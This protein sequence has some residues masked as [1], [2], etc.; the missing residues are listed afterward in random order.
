MLAKYLE[1]LSEE[2][3]IFFQLYTNVR[4]WNSLDIAR[5]LAETKGQIIQKQ[6]FFLAQT[7]QRGFSVE[8]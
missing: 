8:I 6:I 1:K 7:I 3:Y 5:T 4:T 2:K